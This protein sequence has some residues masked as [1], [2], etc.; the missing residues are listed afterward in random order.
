MATVC[1]DNGGDIVEPVN[2]DNSEGGD[3]C[4]DPIL[5][6]GEVWKK[7]AVGWN[8]G[9]VMNDASESSVWNFTL[10]SGDA[11]DTRDPGERVITCDQ[12]EC[13]VANC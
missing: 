2:D 13:T 10:R 9:E 1:R 3:M 7:L 11:D 12:Q 8:W 6:D 4:S 5:V